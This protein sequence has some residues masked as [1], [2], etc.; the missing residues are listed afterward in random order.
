MKTVLLAG[1]EP[2]GGETLNPSALAMSALAGRQIAGRRVAT[3]VLP[4][5]FGQ[6]L[7]L[8]RREFQRLRP[9]LVICSGQAAGRGCLSVERVAINIADARLFLHPANQ[10]HRGVMA[11]SRFA[12]RSFAKRR[13]LC[14]QPRFLWPDANPRTT[15]K[16]ARRLHSCPLPARAD[17]PAGEWLPQPAAGSN[18]ARPGNRHCHQPH[19]PPRPAPDRHLVSIRGI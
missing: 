16:R 13:H 12:G 5:I 11:I 6:S 8:L 19:H 3:L 1:F 9:E 18:R 4:C 7:H 2:F 17:P 10:D 14:L 15:P